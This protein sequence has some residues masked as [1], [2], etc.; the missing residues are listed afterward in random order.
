MITR[1]QFVS[2]AVL[3]V[4]L[5]TMFI[6][7]GQVGE[8]WGTGGS[9]AVMVVIVLISGSVIHYA[10][11][12]KQIARESI[13]KRRYHRLFPI[14]ICYALVSSF[15][16]LF[17][18]LDKD[19]GTRFVVYISLFFATILFAFTVRLVFRVVISD[20]VFSRWEVISSIL[21]LYPITGI[22]FAA[23]Y[24]VLPESISGSKSSFDLIYFSFTT[25]STTGYGDMSPSTV[26]ARIISMI[27]GF[28][29][30]YVLIGVLIA[31][32][33]NLPEII[34]HEDRDRQ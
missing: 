14:L 17:N 27:E 9:I 26:P 11:G 28:V 18:D 12:D 13:E 8:R 1:R 6:T 4:L 19:D 32:A 10:M 29:G 31:G 22:Y 24:R 16:V 23:S 21:I 7:L 5:V 2:Y 15:S 20:R 25:L 33:F 3:A 30:G 34:R